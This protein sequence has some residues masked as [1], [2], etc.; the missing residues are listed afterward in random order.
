MSGRFFRWAVSLLMPL[1]LMACDRDDTTTT[2]NGDGSL[3]LAVPPLLMTRAV[4]VNNLVPRVSVNG[5]VQDFERTSDAGWTTRLVV[6][7]GQRLDIEILWIEI[8]GNRRLPLA[9]YRFPVTTVDRDR[10]IRV[11][12]EDYRTDGLGFDF[13]IDGVSNLSERIANTDPFDPRD[14]GPDF[15]KVFLP[16]IEPEEAPQIDGDYDEVWDRAQ[17]RDRDRL[18]LNIDNLMID[19]GAV[20]LDGTTEYRWAGMHDGQ[21]LYL[22]VFGEQ[23]DG[24]TSFG[25]STPDLWNDDAVEIFWDGDNSKQQGYDGVDDRQ[26][27]FPLS[28][29]GELR[30]NG[31]EVPDGRFLLGFRSAPLDVAA[32]DFA[33]CLC[34]GTQHLYEIRIELAA[35]GIAVDR[36]F[37]FEIQLND[38][39]D[40]ELREVKW[41]WF[42]PARVNND[43]DNTKDSPVFMSTARLQPRLGS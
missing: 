34:E 33:T 15:A 28:P 6:P 40:G 35:A 22:L 14:P 24:Q 7:E 5:V 18:R 4:E 42:H 17:F 8:I 2:L 31:S 9:D 39:R 1:S 27:I 36:T 19:Q 38:D 37:G 21:Y 13:D 20:R 3:S 41:G 30:P 10:S 25:D 11:F 29:F 16:F 43:V 32:F 26:I 12:P 23:A